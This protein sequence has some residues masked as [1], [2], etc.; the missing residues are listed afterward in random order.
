MNTPRVS[1]RSAEPHDEILLYRW[2]NSP[3]SRAQAL[4]T[5]DPISPETHAHWYRDIL[6]DRNA[7]ISIIEIAGQPVGQIRISGAPPSS[8]IDIYIVPSMRQQGVAQAALRQAIADRLKTHVASR[9]IAR[10]LAPNVASRALFKS[11]GF[12][13]I[14]SSDDC[15]VYEL[16]QTKA[17]P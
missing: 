12:E 7:H 8:E 17:A 2:V 11:I 15:L 9:F 14:V 3:D 4:R 10:I 5:K 16:Q 13:L 1:L 6:A